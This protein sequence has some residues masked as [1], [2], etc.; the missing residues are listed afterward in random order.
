V[1]SDHG[2]RKNDVLQRSRAFLEAV[3]KS[4]L[5][6]IAAVDLEGRQAYVNPAFCKMV[7]W[8]S[9]ELLG[10]T[11]PFVYWPPEE[12]PAIRRALELTMQGEAPS[13]GFELRFKRKTGERFYA[14][15]L[16][17]PLIDTDGSFM[18]WLASLYDINERKLGEENLKKSQMQLAEAQRVAHIGS[19]EWDVLQDK[20][21]W[22][23]E[24]YRIHGLDLTSGPF[25]Y[26]SFLES[27]HPD[28]RNMVHSNVE[29]S[30]HRH[31]PFHF[32][33]RIRR[34]DGSVRILEAQGQVAFDARGAPLRITGTAQDITERKGA[35]E[36]QLRLMEERVARA[37]AEEAIHARDD[38]LS[39]ASHELRTPLTALKLQIQG[40]TRYAIAS[41]EPT[42]Q[43][44]F[45]PKLAIVQRQA[46]RLEKLI[47]N[48][49]DVSRTTAGRLSLQLEEVDLVP[50]VHEMAAS[51]QDQFLKAGCRLSLRANGAIVGRWD[52]LRIDQIVDNLLSNALKYGAGQP[53]EV[54]VEES[55]GIAR[56]TVSDHGIGIAPKDQV[57]IFQRFERAVSEHHFGGMGLGL[58]ITRQVIEAMG[59][60]VRVFSELGKGATFIVELPLAGPPSG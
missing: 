21:W 41:L 37:A 11:P 36:I 32:E 23:E 30:L 58:W 38:F 39:V 29:G 12:L 16:L 1:P 52:K 24:L 20:V 9:E 57:R 47:S 14:Q 13:H 43:K 26:K 18:G 6:G 27:V 3:E 44:F 45:L 8:T 2:E 28:D 59:G 51:V 56:L 50:A 46:D 10:A 31:Q 53:I 42:A 34:P 4:T 35:E 19:W 5:A 49:L 40:A 7:Q 15:L 22:S 33:Y 60:H 48:L 54:T 55:E 25:D 17:A